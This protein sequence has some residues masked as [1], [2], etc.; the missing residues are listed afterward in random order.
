MATNN[1]AGLQ[2]AYDNYVRLLV[3]LTEVIANPTRANV[4]AVIA[5]ADASG[6]LA[7][8]PTWTL[9]GETYDW[10]G[11]QTMIMDKLAALKSLIQLEGGPYE[12]RTRPL[13]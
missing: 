8:K 7:P 2:R 3:M 6:V 4:D 12:V 5:S 13:L 11:Y 1:V 10:L 9:D